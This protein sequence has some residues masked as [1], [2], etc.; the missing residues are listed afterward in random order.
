MQILVSNDE[1]R[2]D[3]SI[4]HWRFEDN[5]AASDYTI[6]YMVSYSVSKRV[7]QPDRQSASQLVS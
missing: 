5:T 2:V 1:T 3:C 6:C 4:Y 7:S